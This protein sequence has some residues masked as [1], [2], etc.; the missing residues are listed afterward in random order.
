[1]IDVKKILGSNFKEDITVAE[2]V[3]L[4]AKDESMVEAS[5]LAEMKKQRDKANKEAGDYRKQLNANKTAEELAEI[6]RNE[7][8]EALMKANN[9]LSKQLKVMENAKKFVSMGYEEELANAT[10]SALYEG[11]METFFKN[12][13]IFNE[14]QLKALKEQQ[15]KDT[16]V[17]KKTIVEPKK[18]DIR[19]MSLEEITKL[20]NDN[21]E[22]FKELTG[23]TI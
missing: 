9:E 20:A 8:Y 15:L 13:N 19:A 5:A 6:K 1:M 4:L 11:D 14:G 2:L 22:A 23:R 10:A 3:E 7:E 16:P 18:M 21:P 12:Q 17:P